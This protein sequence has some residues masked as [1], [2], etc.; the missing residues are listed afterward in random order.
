MTCYVS[1]SVAIHFL[2]R[3]ILSSLRWNYRA[4]NQDR[5]AIDHNGLAG[6]EPF[7]HQKQIGLCNVAA[8]SAAPAA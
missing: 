8:A 7:L 3:I 5:T 4:L 6:A 1:A 2:E